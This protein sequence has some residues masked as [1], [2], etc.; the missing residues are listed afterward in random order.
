[1]D[2]KNRAVKHSQR[3]A[4][5]VEGVT[6]PIKRLPASQVIEYSSNHIVFLLWKLDH[7][8]KNFVPYIVK[9]CEKIHYQSHSAV[10]A[11]LNSVETN[12]AERELQMWW[13]AACGSNAE[14]RTQGSDVKRTVKEAASK[15][16]VP[17]KNNAISVQLE[18]KWKSFTPLRLSI[19][20]GFFHMDC[21]STA[22]TVRLTSDE[23]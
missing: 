14:C 2:S 4:R 11:G 18:P 8:M 3:R 7:I 20:M 9:G 19:T 23:R 10:S 17:R 13:N 15:F 6:E 12:V 1:M 22:Q 21:I 5:K 16:L